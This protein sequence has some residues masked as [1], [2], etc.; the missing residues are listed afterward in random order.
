M[1]GAYPRIRW[2]SARDFAYSRIGCLQIWW[3]L[4]LVCGKRKWQKVGKNFQTI[5]VLLQCEQPRHPTHQ[6]FFRLQF[7]SQN[8]VHTFV[9]WNTHY[10][11][12]YAHFYSTVIQHDMVD[13]FSHIWDNSRSWTSI[14]GFTVCDY[15]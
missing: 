1:E 12:Y 5:Q 6:L 9:I 8:S 3:D 7:F 15:V 10:V 14:T 2:W 13:F 4:C 11:C